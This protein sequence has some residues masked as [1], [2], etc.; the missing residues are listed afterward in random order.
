L[1]SWPSSGATHF[2]YAQSRPGKIPHRTVHPL[3]PSASKHSTIKTFLIYSLLQFSKLVFLEFNIKRQLWKSPLSFFSYG[4][5]VTLLS[6]YCRILQSG[7][8][9]CFQWPGFR[10]LSWVL[11]PYSQF[12]MASEPNALTGR[13]LISNPRILPIHDWSFCPYLRIG[14]YKNHFWHGDLYNICPNN[15]LL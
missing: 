8:T 9:D 13:T 1:G 14:E 3:N 6:S 5:K 12:P 15:H 2:M 10:I 11:F 4:L 7:N